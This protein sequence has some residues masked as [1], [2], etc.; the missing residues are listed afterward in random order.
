G[1]FD[2]PHR[3]YLLQPQGQLSTAE[4]YEQLIVGQNGGAPVFLKDVATPKQTVQ[5]ERIDMRFWAR[6]YP[7][8]G[9]TVVVDVFRRAGGSAGEVTTSV[10]DR[11]PSIEG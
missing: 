7:T 9:A 3:T 4:Q 10:R 5:D 2:G 1:Q 6:G 8:P 11:L